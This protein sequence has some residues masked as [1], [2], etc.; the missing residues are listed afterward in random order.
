[1]NETLDYFDFQSDF[2]DVYQ[3]SCVPRYG[4]MVEECASF[5]ARVLPGDSAVRILDLGCGTGN[6]AQRIAEIFPQTKLVCMDG[7]Q[8]MLDRAKQKLFAHRDMTIEF[9]LQDLTL[10]GWASSWSDNEFDAVVSVLVLE[11][12]PFHVYRNVLPQCRRIL[13]PDGWLLTVE[14]YEAG[15]LTELYWRELN[16]LEEQAVQK[17]TISK[18]WLQK[19]KALSLRH[20]KHYFTTLDERKYWWQEAGF[21]GVDCVWKYYCVGLLI[22]KKTEAKRRVP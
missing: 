7:S 2:F 10:E 19:M 18:S 11:H 13:K 1:M 4:E 22:G 5:L 16:E 17:G 9:V 3:K 6:T 21:A 8:K 20:E 12:L 15:L 14:G